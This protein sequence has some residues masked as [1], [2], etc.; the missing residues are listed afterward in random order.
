MNFAI[1]SAVSTK[2]QATPDKVSLEAQEDKSRALGLSKGWKETCPPFRIPGASRSF[3]V[4]LSDAEADIPPLAA[5]LDAAKSRRFDIL[6]FY[7]YDRLG[8]LANMIATALRFY[9]VQLLSVSQ[10]TEVQSPETFDPYQ[11]DSE[12]N[13]RIMSQMIQQFRIADMRR[14][15]RSGMEKRVNE[16]L[17]SLRLP[18]AYSKPTDSPKAIATLSPNHEQIV[19][20]IKDLFLHGQSYYDIVRILNERGIPSPNGAA[21]SHSAVRII[22]LNPF[23][24]GKV[25]FGRRRLVRDVRL[26]KKSMVNNPNPLMLEGK[27]TPVYSWQTYQAILAEAAR[28]ESLPRNNCYQFSGLLT[29]SVCDS[30]LYHG[31]QD[32]W[33]CKP[34]DHIGITNREALA[35]IPAAI[36]KALRDVD[37]TATHTTTPK[38]TSAEKQELTRQ[39]RRIQQAYESEVYSLAE[40]DKKIKDIDSRLNALKDKEN[41]TL[42]DQAGYAAFIETLTAARLV[43]ADIPRWLTTAD[44]RQVNLL[45]RRLFRTITLTPD[46]KITPHFLEY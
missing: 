23:Y 7:S 44:P 27:H 8:D 1:L 13:M 4:N 26:G 14:K 21:W 31:K 38:H 5:M 2:E 11:S 29:C 30:T 9:G 17:N 39:R 20:E 40:A 43:V 42:R 3:Y 41:S 36:Q 33:R 34:L 19:L 46:I 24:A 22:L 32:T 16:G 45:L 15:F 35:L 28:R 12:S 10:G 18:Y 6:I 25:F 37:S